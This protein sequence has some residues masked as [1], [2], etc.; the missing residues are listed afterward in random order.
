MKKVKY[1]IAKGELFGLA[2]EGDEVDGYILFDGHDNQCMLY[3]P[4]NRD[5]GMTCA[6]LV[7]A[8]SSFDGIYMKMEENYINLTSKDVELIER[9]MSK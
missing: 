9:S 8:E 1:R 5:K 2:Q 7:I 4:E 6:S 3:F